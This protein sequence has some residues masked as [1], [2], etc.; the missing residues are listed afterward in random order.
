M[1]IIQEQVEYYSNSL[2]NYSNVCRDTGN[3]IITHNDRWYNCFGY[4]V[5]TYDWEDCEDFVDY[6]EYSDIELGSLTKE[7]MLNENLMTML[8]CFLER[9]ITARQI[10]RISDATSAERVIAMRVGLDDFH[11]AR[12]GSDG[13][14][15]HKPG[16]GCVREMTDEEF[17]SDCWCKQTAFHYT[18]EII[19]IA[20]PK[21]E[22]LC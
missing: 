2:R 22:E 9:F 13:I 14:W 6:T 3:A 20:L 8:E 18:S 17:W 10:S 12:L 7:E 19:L 16:R 15:T 1:E 5:G 4:A 21:E 11:F